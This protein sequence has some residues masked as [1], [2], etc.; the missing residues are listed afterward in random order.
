MK[1]HREIENVFQAG[2]ESQYQK[3][4]DTGRRSAADQRKSKED[5]EEKRVKKQAD[6]EQ[7]C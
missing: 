7:I 3:K 1:I 2:R 6:R 5:G 4:A